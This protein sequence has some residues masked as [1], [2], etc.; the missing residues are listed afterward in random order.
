MADKQY[1][2]YVITLDR[3]M[4]PRK[5]ADDLSLVPGLDEHLVSVTDL[6]NDSHIY[7]DTY[8]VHDP[9]ERKAPRWSRFLPCLR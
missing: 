2:K 9:E 5:L 6:Q 4:W 7:G 1:Y 3:P 8:I